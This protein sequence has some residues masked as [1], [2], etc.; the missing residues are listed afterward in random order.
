MTYKDKGRLSLTGR[1]CFREGGWE[2][3]KFSTPS[4]KR[5]FRSLSLL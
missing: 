1:H 5:H 2:E 4:V 3:G